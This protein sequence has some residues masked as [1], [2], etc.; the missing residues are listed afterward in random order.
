MVQ[1]PNYAT[2]TVWPGDIAKPEGITVVEVTWPEMNNFKQK[3]HDELDALVE[4]RMYEQD[5]RSFERKYLSNIGIYEFYGATPYLVL[6]DKGVE[7]SA[8]VARP[9]TSKSKNAWGRYVNHYLAYTRPMKR[10]QGYASWGE[11][12]LQEAWASRG[13]N[14]LKTLCQSWLGICYH[15]HLRDHV[16]GINPKGELVI[17][18]PLNPQEDFPPGVPIK[19]R[20]F[21]RGETELTVSELRVILSNPQ[22]IFRRSLD[23]IDA[24]LEKRSWRRNT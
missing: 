17:D 3:V 16:W 2:E 10:R 13:Y 20:K 11:F 4:A 8:H 7:V 19:A 5:Q 21:A 24:V 18:S 9:A 23:E 14:R 1:T 22:G 12:I 15:E 6:D